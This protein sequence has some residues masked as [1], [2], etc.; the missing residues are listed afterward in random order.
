MSGYY[1]AALARRLRSKKTSFDGSVVTQYMA[2]LSMEIFIAFAFVAMCLFLLFTFA[3]CAWSPTTTERPMDS[4]IKE[5]QRNQGYQDHCQT[6]QQLRWF[7]LD[8]AT[9]SE[10]EE[11]EIPLQLSLKTQFFIVHFPAFQVA[12]SLQQRL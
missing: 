10:T 5:Q 11:Y 6:F 4:E 12:A 7:S 1:L 9:L 2:H 8:V 3:I